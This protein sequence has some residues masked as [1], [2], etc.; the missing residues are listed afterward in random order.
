MYS[1]PNQNII[2]IH[3]SSYIRNFL[4]IGIDEWQE[5]SKVLTPSAFKIYLYLASNK[6][7]YTFALSKQD[8]KDRLGISFTR[9]YE[10]IS[11]MKKLH[12]ICSDGGNRL[13]F[14]TK[15]NLEYEKEFGIQ[16]WEKPNLENEKP[17]TE[18]TDLKLE[19]DIPKSNIEIYRID[20]KDNNINN[21]VSV[22]GDS[23]KGENYAKI[24]GFHG[25]ERSNAV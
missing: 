12:Y 14:F 4:Q 9:Y 24:L 25:G 21:T 1:Y 19:E 16:D 7:N 8:I 3:K 13:H 23:I 2:I 20:N 5:A 15:P 10:A 6:N 11:L 18:E 17:K 22:C